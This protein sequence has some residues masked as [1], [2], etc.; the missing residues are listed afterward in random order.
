MAARNPT[1]YTQWIDESALV[2]G[3]P[4]LEATPDAILNDQEFILD[5]PTLVMS[6]TG[7]WPFHSNAGAYATMTRFYAR[8]KDICGEAGFATNEI[9]CQV[10]LRCWVDSTS[11]AGDLRLVNV[12]APA[13]ADTTSTISFSTASGIYTPTWIFAGADVMNMKSGGIENEIEM[14]MRVTAGSPAEINCNGI[15]IIAPVT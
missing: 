4:I 10:Y 12:N 13:V 3:Q 9:G 11:C 2:S 15:A 7:G 5:Q 14:Q 8:C 1:A 6:W